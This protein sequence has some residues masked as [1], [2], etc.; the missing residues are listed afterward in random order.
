MVNRRD[1]LKNAVLLSLTPTIP[2]FLRS[3][4]A[5]PRNS[6]ERILVVLQLSGGNDGLNTIVP[7]KDDGY[8]SNRTALRLPADKLIAIDEST[9]FHPNMQAMSDLLQDNRLA[10]VQGV[11][12]PNPNRSHDVSMDVWH[13]A[14]TDQED[15]R[16]NGWLGNALDRMPISH[17]VPAS[18]LVADQETPTALR[19][20]R[21]LSITLD[22]LKEFAG[23]Y[24]ARQL[25]IAEGDDSITE[26]MKRSALDAYATTD[27]VASIA[28]RDGAGR[29]ENLSKL[30]SN[31]A[32]RLKVV[33]DLIQADFGPRVYYC[34]QPGYDT[35][36]VQLRDHADL[37]STL[38]TSLKAF[39]EDMQASGLGDQV[40]VMCFSEFG[41][42][43][44]EN[45]SEG[46]DHGTAGP[47]FLAGNQ[48]QAG[49][50]GSP[51]NLQKLEGNAPGY[52]VD[53]RSIYAE[54]LN[55][56]LNVPQAPQRQAWPAPMELLKS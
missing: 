42:Q 8:L 12:Y 45:A 38:S 18:L 54:V 37:L 47:V 52:T 31:L 50:H 49:L 41:R 13:T 28:A 1:I 56:W 9:A 46:T 26:F 5:A 34:M 27:R 32:R 29:N 15:H 6:K 24:A 44:K 4:V 40:L 22:S 23:D 11:G 55:N 16:G 19:G 39:L 21:S 33:A 51:V 20:R 25:Q 30:R 48:V 36:S 43:V 35:H 14:S 10:I 53:F 17:E 2:A 7:F 3:A